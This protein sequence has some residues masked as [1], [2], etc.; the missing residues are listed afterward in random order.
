MDKLPDQPTSLSIVV[1]EPAVRA[2]LQAIHFTLE[3]W[4]GQEE[5]D[6]LELQNLRTFLQGA[7]LE[8]RYL[9]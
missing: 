6:Q 8:F 7:M 5:I 2:L 4:T 1:D 3:K 9:D